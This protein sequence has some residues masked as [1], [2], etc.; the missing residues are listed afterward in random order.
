MTHRRGLCQQSCAPRPA[1]LRG[2]LDSESHRWAVAGDTPSLF[3]VCGGV[4]ALSVLSGKVMSRARRVAGCATCPSRLASLRPCVN[5]ATFADR[6]V[7]C[8]NDGT[9]LNQR[10]VQGLVLRSARRAKLKDVGV[11][12]LRHTFCSHLAMKGAGARAIQELAGHQDLST[13]QRYM[14]VSPA[15]V[16]SAIRLLDSSAV[17]PSRGDCGETGIVFAETVNR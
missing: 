12:V 14:H 9:S 1:E 11:H 13:T 7:L 17:L 8:A 6:A 2:F 10:A 15:A 4:C 3:A 16:E 5:I